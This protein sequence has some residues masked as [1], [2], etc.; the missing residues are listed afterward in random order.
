MSFSAPGSPPP[1]PGPY[2]GQPYPAQP[3]AGQPHPG[4][5][6]PGQPYPGPP[7]YPGPPPPVDVLRSPQGLAT[8]LTVL[9][10]VAGAVNLFSAGANLFAWSLMKDLIADAD[11]V[12][13][14]SLAQ[15]DG[16]TALAG[17]LQLL[18]LLGTATVFIIWFH[19]VRV[20]GEIFRPDVFT[21]GRGWA[22]GAWFVPIGNLF[23]PFRTARQIW[24]ASTQFAPDGSHRPV[25]AAPLTAWWLVWVLAACADRVFSQMY[26]HAET[27]EAVRDAS[28]VGVFSDLLMVAA[29]ALAVLFVRKLTALQNTKA[30]QGPYAA[31]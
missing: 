31:A 12:A 23:L 3:Y 9:L 21:L 5:Q 29:A 4:Q 18:I 13:E 24:T 20:N 16:L 26:K 10:S 11:G 25:S 7:V 2:Q 15:S 8:A 22:I 19:R 27:P 28:A 17:G 30:V 14:E 1:P 6:Y